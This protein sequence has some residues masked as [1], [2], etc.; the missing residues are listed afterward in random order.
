LALL[1]AGVTA[2]SDKTNGSAVPGGPTGNQTGSTTTTSKGTGSSSP[3]SG[4]SSP[5]AGKDPCS[6]LTASAQGKLGVS[7]GAKH[8]VGSGRGCRWQQRGPSETIIFDIAIYDRAGIKDLPNDIV[9]NKLPNIGKHE[10]VQNP[11]K[12]GGACA[13]ILGVTDT[14][15]VT[16]QAVAGVNL[17]KGCELAMQMAQ[18]VEPEL[19]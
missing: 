7:N 6:L 5:L 1:L 4:S 16:A 13:V 10:A 2:C 17:Q 12:Q 8:D 14:S 9:I 3:T 19:P 18:L 15:R 11:A